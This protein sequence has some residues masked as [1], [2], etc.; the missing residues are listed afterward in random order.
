MFE[1]DT[2]MAGCFR[3]VSY[4]RLATAPVETAIGLCGMLG[5]EFRDE[6]LHLSADGWHGNSS[7]RHHSRDVYSV[8]VDRWKSV[9]PRV[10]VETADFLCGPEMLLTPYRPMERPDPEHVLEF[11]VEADKQPGAW[12]SDTGDVLR[13]FGC[14]LV[15]LAMVRS[16]R[17]YES[18]LIRRCFLLEKAYA[19]IRALYPASN[20]FGAAE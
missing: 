13:D 11:F 19:A 6:M 9:L 18:G 17:P 14:E 10:L 4:E 8:T 7:Y 5:L 1:A 3:C 2:V 20:S 16:D 12:R 15:R